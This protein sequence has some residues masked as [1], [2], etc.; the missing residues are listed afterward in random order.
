MG[1]GIFQKLIAW[2]HLFA[3]EVR[4]PH[5]SFDLPNADIG[6]FINKWDV[7]SFAGLAPVSGTTGL[8]P[9]KMPTATQQHKEEYF[10]KCHKEYVQIHDM[11]LIDDLDDGK[12]A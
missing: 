11:A 12:Q 9:S 4:E 5:P 8:N 2:Y 6:I 7:G 10:C 1:I 3:H